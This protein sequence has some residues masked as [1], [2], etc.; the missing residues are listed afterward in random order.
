L[1]PSTALMR[2]Q[3]WVVLSRNLIL[4]GD[5][6]H[7]F[8]GDKKKTKW[9]NSIFFQ[10]TASISRINPVGGIPWRKIGFFSPVRNI[11]LKTGVKT[12]K[13]IVSGLVGIFELIMK[14]PGK[15]V[16]CACSRRPL[17]GATSRY[18]GCA[19]RFIDSPGHP[20]SCILL[21]CWRDDRRRSRL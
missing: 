17:V 13:V 5:K 11:L 20:I 3:E 14:S 2:R 6:N 21:K 1:I 12:V 16:P 15:A 4:G 18:T 8:E 9:R 10:S 7:T 19:P